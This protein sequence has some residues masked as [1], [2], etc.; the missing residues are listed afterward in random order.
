LIAPGTSGYGSAGTVIVSTM[1]LADGSFTLPRPYTCPANSGLVYI[2]ATGGNA[3][4]GKNTDIALAAILGPCSALTAAT[5]VSINEVTTVA[6]AYALAPF[7]T[8]T[9]GS[10]AIG[11]SPGNLQGLYNA[12][13]SAN[14]LASFTTGVAHAT[15]DFP[16]IV[17][18]TAE[19]NTLADIL[20]SCINQ[21]TVSAPLGN[22]ATLLSDA[23]PSKGPAPT[24]TFQA[25][26]DIALNP[27]NNTTELF[28]LVPALAPF[29]T[30]LSMAPPDFSVALGFNGGGIT[31]GGGTVA[32]AIDALGDAWITTGVQNANVHSLTE[33]SPAGVYL[34]GS[35][36]GASTGFDSSTLN[37]PIGIAIDQSGFIY[38]ANNGQNDILKFNSDGTPNSTI[39]ATSLSG[40]NGITI[41][42][43]AN[44]WIADYNQNLNHVTEITAGTEAANSPFSTGYGGVDIAAG[45]L[46]IWETDYASY[47]VS[48]IDLSSFAVN[49][50][51]IGG[52]SG[53]I[54]VDHTNNAWIAVTG[55]G[56]VFEINDGGTVLSP[57]G[58]YV[59]PNGG[60]QNIT[61]DGL[62]NIFAGGYL[63]NSSM[64]ALVEFSNAGMLLSPDNGFYGSNVI[65]V[66][67]EPPE[68][69]HI[70]GS[71]NVW[72]AGSDNGSGLP[73]YVAEVIGIA[74]PVVTPRAVA[75]TN[76]TLGTRP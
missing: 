41:D 43:A 16:G 56:N 8:L 22:C 15:G 3:G 62:G 57:Y 63:G 59:Y 35:T 18:P 46:A 17:P 2:L 67:P 68:G 69:I 60:V 47:D 75:I 9:A 72:I 26:I 73:D 74:A 38:V 11:T 32:V 30:P 12:A 6:A 65:P 45:P 34:S 36:V 27:G 71:G 52:P 31:L 44:V 48:R 76:N 55:N 40:P 4:G 13:G 21:G 54:A 28:G 7:A 61:V 37:S 66:V 29:Q 5:S 49:N 20:S 42:G 70:D 50:I 53:G 19:I 10:T 24:D 14:N 1:S 51:N 23:T 33:I 64:G 25:A 58:G 39:T